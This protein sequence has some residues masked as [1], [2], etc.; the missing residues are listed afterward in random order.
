MTCQ[1]PFIPCIALLYFLY[2]HTNNNVQFKFGGLCTHVV[3][4]YVADFK[5]WFKFHG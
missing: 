5:L 3:L 1:V 2:P 4:N